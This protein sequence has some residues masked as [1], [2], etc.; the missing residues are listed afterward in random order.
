MHARR[1]NTTLPRRSAHYWPL[2][3]DSLS[4][5]PSVHAFL[6]IRDTIC[7]MEIRMINVFTI[8]QHGNEIVAQDTPMKPQVIDFNSNALKQ[9]CGSFRLS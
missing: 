3:I 4:V 8:N 9:S 6:H 1:D 2:I 7:Q 5:V